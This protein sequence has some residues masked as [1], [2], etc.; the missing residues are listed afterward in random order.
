MP[1]WK[2]RR[3]MN[4]NQRPVT[5]CD[6]IN[7]L[8]RGSLSSIEFVQDYVQLRFDGPLLTAYTLPTVVWGSGR[9]EPG[10]DGYRDALCW[11]IGCRVERTECDDRRIMIAFESGAEVS[12]SLLD[13]DY[14]G[15]EA[16][17]FSLDESLRWVA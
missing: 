5:L 7:E 14:R 1:K 3:P 17:Q 13:N 15:A 10:E 4:A 9:I 8:V 2:L 6:A 16:L 11:Q 12:V